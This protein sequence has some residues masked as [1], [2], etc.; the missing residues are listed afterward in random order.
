MTWAIHLPYLHSTHTHTP[1]PTDHSWFNNFH[2][3]KL[4]LEYRLTKASCITILLWFVCGGGGSNQA[5]ISHQS[6][7][8]MQSILACTM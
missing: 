7:G 6:D 3:Q 5:S 1:A 4:E 2:I 8:I